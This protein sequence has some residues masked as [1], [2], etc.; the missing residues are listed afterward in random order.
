M[1]F[2]LSAVDDGGVVDGGDA[3][4]GVS[5]FVFVSV[6]VE[7]AV[8]VVALEAVAIEGRGDIYGFELSV[9]ECVFD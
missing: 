2:A 9:T 4:V 5:C 3:F 1:S 6:Y 7:P 8:W